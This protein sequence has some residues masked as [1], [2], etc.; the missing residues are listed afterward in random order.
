MYWGKQEI[1]KR[2]IEKVIS[3]IN[4]ERDLVTNKLVFFFS[5]LLRLFLGFDLSLTIRMSWWVT[6]WFGAGG[7]YIF[8]EDFGGLRPLSADDPS[9]SSG[10]ILWRECHVIS[11]RSVHNLSS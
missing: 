5:L 10:P 2:K 4:V 7:T 8:T 11:H 1:K 6:V 9:A 3:V